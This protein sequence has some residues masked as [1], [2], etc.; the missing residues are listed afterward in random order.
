MKGGDEHEH[1]FGCLPSGDRSVSSPITVFFCPRD[2]YNEGPYSNR[3][4]S[5]AP[6]SVGSSPLAAAVPPPPPPPLPPPLLPFPSVTTSLQPGPLGVPIAPLPLPYPFS[7]AAVDLRRIN[8]SQSIG[9]RPPTANSNISQF[10]MGTQL[11]AS[12]SRRNSAQEVTSSRSPPT[13]HSRKSSQASVYIGLGIVESRRDGGGSQQERLSPVKQELTGGSPFITTPETK[14]A[15]SP[16]S[17][18]LKCDESVPDCLNCRKGNREC[19]RGL[20]LNFIDIQTKPIPY[21]PTVSN[22]NVDFLDESRLIASEYVG[23]VN[24][25]SRIEQA[26]TTPPREAG[27][28]GQATK[29]RRPSGHAAGSPGNGRERK[30]TIEPG[31]GH[32]AANSLA[33]EKSGAGG[34]RKKN[35]SRDEFYNAPSPRMTARAVPSV[36]TERAIS[37]EGKSSLSVI[38]NESSQRKHVYETGGD[39]WSAASSTVPREA[40]SPSTASWRSGHIGS[41][42]KG[43][44]NTAH[45][46][47]ATDLLNDNM[48][49]DRPTSASTRAALVR[50]HDRKVGFNATAGAFHIDRSNDRSTEAKGEREYLSSPDEVLF[51]QVFVEEVG[52]WMDS[53]DNDKHFSR[54]VPFLALQSPMLLNAS[55]ACGV[56]HLTLVNQSYKDD[57]ALFYY[58]TAT[59]QL[60]RTLQ[61]PSRNIAECATTAVVL[62]VYEIM[63]EKPTE[64]MSHIA[65]ARALIRECGWDARSKGIGAACFWLNIGMEVLSCLAFHWPISWD[66]DQWGLDLAFAGGDNSSTV[67]GDDETWVHRMF[68]IVAKIANFEANTPHFQEASPQSE[69]ARSQSRMEE[70]KNLNYLYRGVASVAIRSLATAALVLRDPREQ[71]E[72]VSLLRNINAQTGWRINK[73]YSELQQAWG[74]DIKNPASS[75]AAAATTAPP[76]ASTPDPSPGGEIANRLGFPSHARFGPVASTLPPR[77]NVPAGPALTT[78]FTAHRRDL[79]GTVSTVP[80]GLPH[81]LLVR[82]TTPIA[83]PVSSVASAFPSTRLSPATAAPRPYRPPQTTN[84]L[85]QADFSLSDHPYKTFYRPPNDTNNPQKY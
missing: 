30:A 49:E 55:L 24:R 15:S 9:S 82:S 3:S 65:G 42:G 12:T 17:A 29:R 80:G 61:D 35:N 34:S 81:H 36:G 37:S 53:L 27:T 21:V 16:S 8:A 73:I 76:F 33:T 18:H 50:D 71:D 69:Q 26:V 57:K 77:A 78:A 56:K 43:S 64:R 1:E 74:R 52:V 84:P 60:L 39:A 38:Q 4:Q 32:S 47:S 63:S 85:L 28:E 10:A 59:T 44:E 66:P 68:Y 23:G 13:P 45:V 58:D 75:A 83:S 67:G 41:G 19:K 11:T 22:W 70:W 51:M 5:S 72:V 79:A 62:N 46:V 7:Q 54:I 48:L 31:H 2:D 14:A 25:Y 6:F 20:R 40:G